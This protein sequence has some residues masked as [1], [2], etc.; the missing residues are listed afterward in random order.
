[1]SCL[2]DY[3]D[4]K[5]CY[6]QTMPEGGFINSLPGISLESIDAIASEDQIT[7]RGVWDDVQAEAFDRFEMDL[8][9]EINR[10]YNLSPY[11]DYDQLICDNKRRL[12]NAWKYLLGNQLMSFR[13]N[14]DRLNRFTLID[15]EKAEKL[16]DQYYAEYKTAL[17]QAVKII[18]LGDCEMCCGGNP[19]TVVWLP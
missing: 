11:C 7:Y 13:V 10:C 19:E 15:A 14:S 6:G 2:T 9:E 5:V 1:M 3:I 8:M 4:I 16:M 12:K 17:A 18:E